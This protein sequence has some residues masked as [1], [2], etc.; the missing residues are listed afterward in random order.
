MYNEQYFD[1]IIDKKHDKSGRIC[2]FTASKNENVLTFMNIYAP[3]DHYKAMEFLKEIEQH[4]NEVKDKYPGTKLII[5]GDYNFVFNKD[6][7]AIGRNSKPQEEKVS[8][9]MKR[10]MTRHS[11]IDSYRQLHSWGGFTWGRDNP[12]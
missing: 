2:S 5:S 9:E 3:N 7:D 12:H 10:I 8:K 6:V 4:I 11:L 1:E